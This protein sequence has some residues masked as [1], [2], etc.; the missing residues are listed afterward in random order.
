MEIH[1]IVELLPKNET[2]MLAA[3][4]WQT[5]GP[6]RRRLFEARPLVEKLWREQPSDEL[7]QAMHLLPHD[8]PIFEQIISSAQGQEVIRAQIAEATKLLKK[9]SST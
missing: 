9:L 1:S 6:A 4:S 2:E 7:Y 5:D 8:W 3:T